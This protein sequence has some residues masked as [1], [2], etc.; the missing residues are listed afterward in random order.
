MDLTLFTHQV[1]CDYWKK[2][3]YFDFDIKEK[4]WNTKNTFPTLRSLISYLELNQNKNIYFTLDKTD[5]FIEEWNNLIVNYDKFDN[6]CMNI[7]KSWKDKIQAFFTTKLRNYTE[8][9]VKNIKLSASESEILEII[10]NFSKEQKQSFINNLQWIENIDFPKNIDIENFSEDDFVSAFLKFNQNSWNILSMFSKF[11]ETELDNLWK[12]IWVLKLKNILD[13]WEENKANSSEEF[14]QKLFHDY[15][16]ILSQIFLH[17]YIHIWSKIYCW[18]KSDDNSWWVLWDLVYKNVCTNNIAFVE[19][20]TP[21]KDLVWSEYRWKEEWK[22]NLIYSMSIEISWWINQVLNQR[23]NYI[24]T[25]WEKFTWEK[26][27]YN[28]KCILLLWNTEKITPDEKKSFEL[29][30]GSI[31]EVEIITFDELFNRI[32]ALYQLLKSN[33]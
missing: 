11:T 3:I 18:W 2:I 31:K 22:E 27:L 5:N 21:E 24:Q 15:N 13:K 6:F 33:D 12:N 10:K 26:N 32:N 9:E 28:S 17:P 30:R 19:I 7:W 23:K 8:E 4:T 16:W 20:K 1:S 14:W 29:F 25:H